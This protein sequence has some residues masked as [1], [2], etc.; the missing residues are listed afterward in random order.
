MGCKLTF[1]SPLLP[2][3]LVSTRSESAIPEIHPVRFALAPT[4]YCI[5]IGCHPTLPSWTLSI[6]AYAHLPCLASLFSPCLLFLPHTLS[7]FHPSMHR[8]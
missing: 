8:L 7:L 1:C 5:V 6:R 3:L 2:F 4:A